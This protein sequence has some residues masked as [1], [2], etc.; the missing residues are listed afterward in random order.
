MST[1][2]QVTRD[3][4]GVP[5]TIEIRSEGRLYKI[6]YSKDRFTFNRQ[7]TTAVLDLLKL[8]YPVENQIKDSSIT[9]F[10]GFAL[11]EFTNADQILYTVPVNKKALVLNL[12]LNT[13]KNG[14][15]GIIPEGIIYMARPSTNEQH[16]L[17]HHIWNFTTVDAFNTVISL[18]EPVP[19]GFVFHAFANGSAL[20]T[21]H[22]LV[23]LEEL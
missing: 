1:N 14:V 21:P 6:E 4:C 23:L 2:M 16:H 17:I 18:A 8:V 22:I 20:V 11:D 12:S 10:A 13:A 5:T 9:E 7:P 19:F 3:S 15:P